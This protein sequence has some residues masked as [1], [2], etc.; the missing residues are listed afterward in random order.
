MGELRHAPQQEKHQHQKKGIGVVTG[1]G[2][3][4]VE[5]TL[6]HGIISTIGI[7]CDRGIE[8]G[9]VLWDEGHLWP[10]APLHKKGCVAA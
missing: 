2:M 5:H 8:I 4:K 1:A 10:Q 9:A 6:K 3:E 7:W